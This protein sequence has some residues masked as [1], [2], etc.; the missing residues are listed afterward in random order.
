MMTLFY[1]LEIYNFCQIAKENPTLWSCLSLVSELKKLRFLSISTV[2]TFFFV[3]VP[4][5]WNQHFSHHQIQSTSLVKSH[6]NICVSAV[7][8]SP[9]FHFP[10]Q[11]SQMAAGGSSLPL[12]NQ[13][14]IAQAA[15][16]ASNVATRATTNILGMQ[17]L[18]RAAVTWTR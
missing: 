3:K 5:F 9:S 18:A 7:C 6:T 8:I 4:K 15:Q 14:I 11:P 2:L 12:P 16:R 1:F 17:D 10:S 13:E